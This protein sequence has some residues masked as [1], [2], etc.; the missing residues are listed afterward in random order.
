[1]NWQDYWAAGRA[2]SVQFAN[3]R[4]FPYIVIDGFMPED[5]AQKA[6]KA[7]PTPDSSVW[8]GNDNPQT[9]NKSTIKYGDGVKDFCLSEQALDI[10][11]LLNGGPFMRF[12]CELSQVE[13]VPDPYFVEGAYHLVGNG[14]K[15]GIHADFSHHPLTGLERRLNLLWYLNPDWKEEYGGS[16]GLYE[17]DLK[18]G[19]S[20]APLFNR[21]VIF[22]TSD[23]SYHGHPEPMKLPEGVYRRSIAMYYYSLPRPEREKKTIQFPCPISAV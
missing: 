6:L 3:A 13:L 9:V 12:V 20:I 23:I 16:L 19:K 18:T 1:M 7:C 4:P 14:G 17:P 8:K 21:A 10:L 2:L 11:Q 15:L 22:A 5:V